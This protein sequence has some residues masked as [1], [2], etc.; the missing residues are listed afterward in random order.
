[1]KIDIFN[2]LFLRSLG[3]FRSRKMP[4]HPLAGSCGHRR[5]FMQIPPDGPKIHISSKYLAN[6]WPGALPRI[7]V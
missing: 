1:M 5:H 4:A 2:H 6:S 3:R 7:L